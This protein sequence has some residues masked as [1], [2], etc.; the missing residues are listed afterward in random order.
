MGAVHR[1]YDRLQGE[2]VAL[3][4][5]QLPQEFLLYADPE[6]TLPT[7]LRLALAREF[8]TLSSLRHPYIISVLD[9]GFDEE[10]QPYYTM[11]L[12]ENGQ[13]LRAA[14]DTLP[15]RE[16]ATLI[17]QVL[18]ALS[19]LHRR[20]VLHRDLKPENVLV[21]NGQV[22]VLDFGLASIR[23]GEDKEFIG[24]SLSYISP[25]VW[26]E[27]P[28]GEA[29]DL[30]AVGVM[31]YEIF[32]GDHPFAPI[33]ADFVTRVLETDP[34]Y[35]RLNTSQS[36]VNVIA[37]LLSKEP[38][39]RF[40]S[41]E[42][43]LDALA[44]ALELTTS[45]E[46]KA[47]R[48]SFLQAASFV[49]RST[50]LKTLKNALKVAQQG[51]GGVWLVGGE[52][53]VGK[54]RL[55]DELR[56][57]ALVSGWQVVRGQAISGGAIP[58]Q[59]WRGAGPQL[60]LNSAI[61]DLDAGVL[62]AI[63]P[64][65]ARLLGRDIPEPPQLDGE[66]AQERL[67]L[68]L[69][70]LLRQ[71]HRPTLLLLEDLQWSNQLSLDVVS[72]LARLANQ[73]QLLIIGTY[74]DDE[75]PRLPEELPKS[76]GL[77][78]L[79][80][81]ADQAILD[82]C[83]SMLGA[84]GS[85]PK[86]IDFLKR[87]TEGNA[88]FLVEIVRAL[89]EESGRL[90]A[91]GATELP[92]HVFTGGIT[93][94][95]ERRLNTV[96]T[97]YHQLLKLAA[98]SGRDLDLHIMRKL[99]EDIPLN[100]WL[101]T[102]QDAAV[103]EVQENK[104]RFAHDKLRAT[105]ITNLE[106]QEQPQLNQQV[107]ETIEAVY[108]DDLTQAHRLANHWH[109]VGNQE[110]ER[111]HAYRAGQ[112]AAG[113][114]ANSEAVT[115]LSRALA[116]TSDQDK[117][118]QYD[119]LLARERLYGFLGNRDMQRHDL[120]LLAQL[121]DILHTQG[122][123]DFRMT[124][125]LQGAAYAEATSDYEAAIIAAESVIDFAQK[126][127]NKEVEAAGTLAW[128][129]ALMRQGQYTAAQ[130]KLT[131]AVTQSEA[132]QADSIRAQSL[133]WRGTGFMEIGELSSARDYYEQALELFHLLHDLVG[134]SEIV[135]NLAIVAHLQGD[136]ATALTNWDVARELNERMGHREGMARIQL[137]MGGTYSD[138]GQYDTAQEFL[139]RALD[140]FQ[141]IE[142]PLGV[143]YVRL[144]LSYLHTKIGKLGAAVA[145]G[146]EGL[147][148][149]QEI[150]SRS[151]QSLAFI[152]L[153]E[154]YLAQNAFSK[155]VEAYQQVIDLWQEQKNPGQVMEGLAG[156]ALTHHQQGHDKEALSQV[157]QIL[158]FIDQGES[159]PANVVYLA[160]YYVLD[161]QKDPRRQAILTAAYDAIQQRANQITDPDLRQSYLTHVVVHRE[162]LTLAENS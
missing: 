159:V 49:G 129:R 23:G 39:D 50:E 61:N 20:L 121:A 30:Y 59:L 42:D 74:R 65:I 41:A 80:R 95:I 4:H 54:T 86:V 33:D 143:C 135:N 11:D 10:S 104:W 153:G 126:A 13:T 106:T 14:G 60:I 58:Y 57:Q 8:Q 150:N 66:A 3:K 113:Q 31:A 131:L 136:T 24:G 71:Q 19:Y 32:A 156:L 110:R 127:Q 47:I 7:D 88:F 29:A 145:Y 46:N 52:S 37:K 6:D 9:Y 140:H 27:E 82:L 146:R 151:L 26:L 124:V 48:E 162:L 138:C 109:V 103:L 45:P 28:Y 91:I 97:Q 158:A 87:E 120:N 128:G 5:I 119:I 123:A 144:N 75:R 92:L 40:A 100:L 15:E 107:A 148:I 44:E 38:K 99:T 111:I 53:G 94:I 72:R 118:H 64:N 17:Q 112:Y 90:G 2:E 51:E 155:G 83:Q 105:L 154:A 139:N 117:S 137:N 142:M 21:A 76:V 152:N 78:K 22:F 122:T 70:S 160:C 18:Q 79:A 85:Q 98:V 116:L 96:P 157:E 25:E 73:H 1:V 93:Q 101:S 108:P 34:D 77:I 125:A 89:A 43:A 35:S 115:F 84:A 133:R 81:L 130:E 141:E 67:L 102:C 147:Q 161:R 16:K 63:V 12:L 132:A 62:R 56:T 114:Y 36:I 149:A 134:E 55:I 68:T 69:I